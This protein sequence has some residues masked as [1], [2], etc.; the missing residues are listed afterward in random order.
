MF[1]NYYGLK[2]VKRSFATLRMTMKKGKTVKDDAREKSKQIIICILQSQVI[3]AAE[4][5]L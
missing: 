2:Q 3:S 5:L 4:R 1:A